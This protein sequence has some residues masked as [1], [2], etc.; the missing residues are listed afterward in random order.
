MSHIVEKVL[1][2][3]AIMHMIFGTLLLRYE[4]TENRLS[5]KRMDIFAHP[6]GKGE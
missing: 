5:K 6:L 1:K 4:N 2:S 3:Y